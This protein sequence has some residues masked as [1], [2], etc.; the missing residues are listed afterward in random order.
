MYSRCAAQ[1]TT[2]FCHF[3]VWKTKLNIV[4][5]RSSSHADG[6]CYCII[7]TPLSAVFWIYDFFRRNKY[8]TDTCQSVTT[9]L[10]LNRRGL[11][12]LTDAGRKRC[13]P[14]TPVPAQTGQCAAAVETVSRVARVQ[15]MG[16]GEM[17]VVL[18]F[19]AV[20]GDARFLAADKVETWRRSSK[21]GD[22]YLHIRTSV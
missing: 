6:V 13:V 4:G 19:V 3:A 22:R 16:V 10:T 2:A 1:E 9:A 20:T 21:D 12:R 5:V 14:H 17:T 11:G 8:T 15:N 7:M 18:D